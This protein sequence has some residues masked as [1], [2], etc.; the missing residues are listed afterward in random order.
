MDF[1]KKNEEQQHQQSYQPDPTRREFIRAEQPKND[2]IEILYDPHVSAPQGKNKSIM[3]Q[4][5]QASEP[6]SDTLKLRNY[7][8]RQMNEFTDNYLFSQVIPSRAVTIINVINTFLLSVVL[9]VAFVV[10]LGL[11][12][13]LRI[14]LVPTDSMKDEISVGSMVIIQPLNSIDEVRIGDILSYTMGNTG[15]IHKVRSVGGDAIV[16]V[17]SNKDD[18][19]YDDEHLRHIIRFD[20]VQGRMVMSI[21]IIGYVIMFVQDYFIIVLSLFLTLLIGLLLSRALIEKKHNDEEFKAFLDKKTEY[22]REAIERE[23]LEKKR[24]QQIAFDNLMHQ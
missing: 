8:R 5:D 10:A 17:G 9:I 4:Y 12:V 1:D 6:S 14:G 3:D 21:P 15:Y 20:A 24:E 19:K 13:G 7:K 11:L 22:E 16:M 18:P 23:Q 2:A